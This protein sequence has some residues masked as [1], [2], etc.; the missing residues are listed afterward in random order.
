MTHTDIKKNGWIVEKLPKAAKPY[1]Y[2]MRLDRP[3]GTWLLLLPGLWAIMLASGGLWA[4]N[5]E[6]ITLV[7]LFTI[8]AVLM[9]GAGCVMND[10]WDRELDKKVKRTASRPIA[11]G[12]VSVKQAIIFIAVLL[13]LGF[14]ILLQMHIVTILLGF[15]TIPLMITY[16]LMKRVTW[17]PQLFL[18]ITF[19]F[20]ALMGWAAVNG[21]VDLPALLLYVGGIFWTL[22]YDTIY[23]DQDKEDDALVGIK[24]SV[25]KLGE[26]AEKTVKTFYGVAFFLFA[27]AFVV[28]DA[29]Y[30]SLIVLMGG[31]LHFTWQL[32]NWKRDDV[33]TA[34]MVF[35]SNRDFGLILLAAAAL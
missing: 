30:I 16:P 34:L 5:D 31:A 20:G 23:A 11:A 6:D 21:T 25:L 33:A 2:L 3:I 14:S 8:G 1:F 32:K 24:S 19:N 7:A 17:W 26:K 28:A 35:R 13:L 22:G 9:R 12:E 15:L 29:G 4:L 27:M 10:L 18:G